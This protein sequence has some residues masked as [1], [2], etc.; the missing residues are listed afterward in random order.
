VNSF[1]TLIQQG[2][3]IL[4]YAAGRFSARLRRCLP[5]P[6]CGQGKRHLRILNKQIEKGVFDTGFI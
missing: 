2:E 6:G 5:M 1:L 4:L 3:G